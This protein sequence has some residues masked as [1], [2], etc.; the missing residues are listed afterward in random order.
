MKDSEICVCTMYQGEL[1]LSHPVTWGK[2]HLFSPAG[3]FH[4]HL[5]TTYSDHTLL[6]PDSDIL[7]SPL[8]PPF[9]SHISHRC[10]GH[11]GSYG[12]R[13][14]MA[15][16]PHCQLLTQSWLDDRLPGPQS[17]LQ[18]ASQWVSLACCISGHAVCM[19]TRCV[20]IH[21]IST[22]GLTVGSSNHSILGE[23]PP[24]STLAP[25]SLFSVFSH[26]FVPFPLSADILFT[27]LHI[28]HIHMWRTG[29]NTS[30]FLPTTLNQYASRKPEA[31]MAIVNES[32]KGEHPLCT[33]FGPAIK[34]QKYWCCW[35]TQYLE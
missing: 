29:K 21:H 13:V 6:S 24:L 3:H 8:S 26:C 5:R 14:I 22:P 27:Y 32:F 35:Q 30:I 19:I 2:F 16:L 10:R 34:S 12:T 18:E 4:T 33:V 15:L 11:G 25:V 31:N 9:T 28:S 17:A 23:I 7:R 20:Y 1:D